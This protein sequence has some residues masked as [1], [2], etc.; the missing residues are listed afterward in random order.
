MA[1]HVTFCEAMV[2]FCFDDLPTKI[3]E[4]L[5]LSRAVHSYVQLRNASNL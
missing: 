1:Q 3:D 4:E 5:E 2:S